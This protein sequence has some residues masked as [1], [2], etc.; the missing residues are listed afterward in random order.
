MTTILKTENYT[1]FKRHPLNRETDPTHVRKLMKA[2]VHDNK[3][4][5]HPIVV[6]KNYEIVSGQHRFE[7]AKTLGLPIFYIKDDHISDEHIISSN[8]H[9]KRMSTGDL[10]RFHARAAGKKDY[11]GLEK[12][13]KQA[14]I[15]AKAAFGLLA[16]SGRQSGKSL[17]DG[18]FK[19]PENLA[20]VD[21][22]IDRYLTFIAF[23]DER[24]IRPLGAF[25][26]ATFTT[27]FR[28]MC[29]HPDFN[30]ELFMDKV[31]D[32]WFELKPQGNI[33][34]WFGLLKKIY[35]FRNR[36]PI[37]AADDESSDGAS[38]SRL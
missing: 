3:L 18:T 7:A 24:Q 13:I 16:V 25:K 12:Y 36:N 26:S 15:S 19:L 2:F 17:A 4:N 20:F 11:I 34:G 10:I 27:A 14:G 22:T 38:E 37:Y 30:F 9:Q 28:R 8:T 31:G 1:V 5:V 21:Q 32:R 23:C 29:Q 6:N 35:N 33:Q